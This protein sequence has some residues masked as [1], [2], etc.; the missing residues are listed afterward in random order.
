MYCFHV[1]L[2][3]NIRDVFL[4]ESDNNAAYL[5]NSVRAPVADSNVEFAKADTA[6]S[7]SSPNFEQAEVSSRGTMCAW[8]PQC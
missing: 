5:E 7:Q 6:E 2:T 8:S 4:P 1:Y 3:R